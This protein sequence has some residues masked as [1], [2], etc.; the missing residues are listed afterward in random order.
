MHIGDLT[1]L[2]SKIVRYSSFYEYS[3]YA[4]T[5]YVN[6]DISKR[7]LLINDKEPFSIKDYEFIIWFG[8]ITIV[9]SYRRKFKNSDDNLRRYLLHE[10]MTLEIFDTQEY[11]TYLTSV[12]SPMIHKDHLLYDYINIKRNELL[13]SDRLY[14][15]KQ[16]IGS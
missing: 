5:M 12:I 14:T 3:G 1:R 6:G 15:L 4:K 9:N 7:T 16:I 11:N 8:F 10:R 2:I 13:K